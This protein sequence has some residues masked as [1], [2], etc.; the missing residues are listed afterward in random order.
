MVAAQI[1]EAFRT[2]GDFFCTTVVVV[3][4]CVFGGVK[5]ED[6]KMSLTGGC[7]DVREM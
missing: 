6:W 2:V 5:V 1:C 4:E 7:V 3:V